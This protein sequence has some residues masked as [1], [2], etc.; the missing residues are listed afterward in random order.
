MKKSILAVIPATLISVQPIFSQTKRAKL[1]SE[2][3]EQKVKRMAWRSKARFGMFIHWGL[4]PV[5]GGARVAENNCMYIFS[6]TKNLHASSCR[7][8]KAMY[9]LHGYCPMDQH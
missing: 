7:I 4:Y 8:T 9:R 5:A 3:P 2:P 1:F 6:T